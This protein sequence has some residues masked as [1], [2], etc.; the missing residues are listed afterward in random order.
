MK[1]LQYDGEEP[2]WA[3][4]DFME[5]L[6]LGPNNQPL[7]ET[8]PFQLKKEIERLKVER[9]D[10]ASELE[11][12]QNMLKMQVD[13]DKKSAYL[14]Q[15]EIEQIKSQI[16]GDNRRIGELSQ[17]IAVRNKNLLEVTKR[18]AQTT[19]GHLTAEALAQIEQ[20]VQKLSRAHKD[21]DVLTEFS[22]ITDE[23]EMAPQ[24][25]VMDF[26]LNTASFDRQRLAQ[27]LGNKELLPGAVQTFATVDFYNHDTR[28]SDLSEGFEPN[29]ST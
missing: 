23:S 21:E 11:R 17:V 3:K 16:Q 24:E 2:L 25:N 8:D 22:V 26:I 6:K 7:D 15:N 9:R 5:K 19:T 1:D 10:L 12:I 28:N 27:L 20:E 18:T 14:Y 29:Y 13:I 4:F